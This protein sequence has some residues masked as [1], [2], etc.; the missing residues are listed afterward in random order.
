MDD[1]TARGSTTTGVP[2]RPLNECD[3]SHSVDELVMV[4]EQSADDILKKYSNKTKLDATTT[5]IT[6]NREQQQSTA[7]TKSTDAIDSTSIYY[8]PD[9]LTQ[10]RAFLDAKR[11]LR[12]VLSSVGSLPVGCNNA[13]HEL[14]VVQM[15]GRNSTL[16]VQDIRLVVLSIGNV[17]CFVEKISKIQKKTMI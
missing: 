10:C 17:W 9:N 11:K 16:I 5:L 2:S 8:D 14:R 6:V 13:S 12:L 15:M 1:L 7:T 3:N 4:N